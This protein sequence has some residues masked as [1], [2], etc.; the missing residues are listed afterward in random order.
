[1]GF[2][3]SQNIYLI[4]NL[5][6]E[7]STP[8]ILLFLYT[9]VRE[10]KIAKVLTHISIA[11]KREILLQEKIILQNMHPQSRIGNGSCISSM[12]CI[13]K[14]NSVQNSKLINK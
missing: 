4:K 5:S 2:K 3:I 14:R 12:Q 1:M 11:V 7:N 8:T 9:Q 6:F 13:I 10:N